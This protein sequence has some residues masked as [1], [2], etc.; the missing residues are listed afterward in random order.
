[1]LDKADLSLA[2]KDLNKQCMENLDWPDGLRKQ[3]S[4]HRELLSGKKLLG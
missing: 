3:S 2:C 1:M 4:C